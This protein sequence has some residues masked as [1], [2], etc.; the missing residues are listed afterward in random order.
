MYLGHFDLGLSITV[1]YFFI[2][3]VGNVYLIKPKTN[4]STYQPSVFYVC[5]RTDYNY[6]GIS[7][8][9]LHLAYCIASWFNNSPERLV[10]GIGVGLVFGLEPHAVTPAM[11]L[12]ADARHV[13]SVRATTPAHVPHA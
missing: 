13:C 10:C 5:C 11:H 8:I 4:R 1:F 9:E 2:K 12:V 3:S 6:I 7:I